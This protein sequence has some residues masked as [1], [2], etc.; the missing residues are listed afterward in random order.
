MEILILHFIFTYTEEQ[1]TLQLSHSEP[2]LLL[3]ELRKTVEITLELEPLN[4]QDIR[5]IKEEFEKLLNS[6]KYRNF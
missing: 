2:R 1:R 6:D 5:A 3:Q 4:D